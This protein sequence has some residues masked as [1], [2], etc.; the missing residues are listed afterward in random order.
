M[1]RDYNQLSNVD[2]DELSATQYD[3]MINDLAPVAPPLVGGVWTWGEYIR[4][5]YWI[6][7][8]D[9][10]NRATPK[11]KITYVTE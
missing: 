1:S 11:V 6:N 4:L 2:Y 5:R 8:I 9:A 10:N 3:G 7:A